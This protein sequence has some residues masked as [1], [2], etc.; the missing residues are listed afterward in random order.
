MACGLHRLDFP[1]HVIVLLAISTLPPLFRSGCTFG[2][3]T[4]ATAIADFCVTLTHNHLFMW[5]ECHSYSLAK[6]EKG[7]FPYLFTAILLQIETKSKA[8]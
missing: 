5:M 7:P 1:S 8:L 3:I 4:A 2:V 6:V